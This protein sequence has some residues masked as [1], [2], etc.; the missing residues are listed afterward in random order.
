MARRDARVPARAGLI[1]ARS[2]ALGLLWLASCGVRART[3]MLAA[4]HAVLEE[5]HGASS[6]PPYMLVDAALDPAADATSASPPPFIVGDLLAARSAEVSFDPLSTYDGSITRQRWRVTHAGAW[7]ALEWSLLSASPRRLR[8]GRDDEL[9]IVPD[10]SDSTSSACPS[11]MVRVEGSTVTASD[12]DVLA[13]QDAVCLAWHEQDTAY[14][15][16]C[17]QASFRATHATECPCFES[18]YR[19]THYA[20]CICHHYD[21]AAYA[22]LRERS[23]WS[24]RA[25]APYCI[26]RDEYPGYGAFPWVEVSW[27][28]AAHACE[29]RGRRLCTEREWTFACEGEDALPYPTGNDLDI[30]RCNVDRPRTVFTTPAV[31]PMSPTFGA[32]VARVWQGARAGAH[33]ACVSPFGVRD[34]AGNVDEW[35]HTM[36]TVDPLE[37]RWVSILKGGYWAEGLNRCRVSTRAH[38]EHFVF[39]QIGFRCC[40]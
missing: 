5:T 22:S 3:P 7:E 31:E 34:M 28:D 14:Q 37:H 29:A 20:M 24:R 27:L 40:R 19:A 16:R 33:P 8:G 32:A 11:D 4:D 35:T 12:D 18:A 36:G 21:G 26:E 1:A 23:H 30:A 25:V 17:E 39:Y 2:C 13:V 6:S 15:P 38:Y 10:R 9:A